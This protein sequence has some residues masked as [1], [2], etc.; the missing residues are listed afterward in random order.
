MCDRMAHRG[1]DDYGAF[2]QTEYGQTVALGHRRLSIIDRAGGHQPLG[3]EDGAVQVVF[4]GEIYNFLELRSD[5]EKRGHRFSTNSD[6]EVLVHLFEE[7]GP[8]MPEFLN[9]MFAFVI[10]DSRTR[11]LFAARDRFGKKPLYYSQDIPGA[12]FAFASELKAFDAIPGFRRDLNARSVAD[13]LAFS[14]VP[15]PAS[16]YQHVQKLPPGHS[17]TLRGSK[18][19]LVRYWEPQF[20]TGAAP[21]YSKGVEEL[22]SLAIDSVKRRMISDV[23]IGAFLSG[24]V[25]SAAVTGVMSQ[26]SPDRVRTFSIGFNVRGFDEL[27]YARITARM[28]RTQHREEV[29]TP[30]IQ[31]AFTSFANQFDEPFADASAIPS[32]YVAR[33]TRQYVTV[34]LSGDGADELFAGYRRYRFGVIEERIRKMF[35]TCFRQTFFQIAGQLY[36]KLD[37]APRAFRAKT[38]LANLAH[39]LGDAYFTSMTA[40]RDAG[41]AQIMSGELRR[42]LRGYDPRECFRERFQVVRELSPLAQLQSVDMD[43]Y[44]PGDILVKADRATMAHSLESRSPWLDY[45][46]AELALRM[47]DAYKLS[48]G[49]GKL[50]FKEAMGAYIPEQIVA[51][52]K[53]GFSPPVAVWLRTALKPVFQKLV[54]R[55]GMERYLSLPEV[56][57]LWSEHQSGLHNHDRRLWSVLVL[58]AW[59]ANFGEDRNADIVAEAAALT[60]R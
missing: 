26:H 23:P 43:T 50:I 12:Q 36:P 53:M 59:D 31:D 37:W 40:F 8:R 11:T 6:T 15:D 18:T 33:M 9:G 55:D 7:A 54:M 22:R 39:E 44:L 20:E 58:A 17:L 13:F 2:T 24:G 57:R 32:L 30:V 19:H 49:T 51:R 52:P 29:V 56:R 45:R 4:N 3:N 5:L 21:S 41:L 14:Y 42:T 10:W 47:P 46:L 16:I 27:E 28:H 38:T 34:A 1:P 25:D 35:P 60:S 48:G